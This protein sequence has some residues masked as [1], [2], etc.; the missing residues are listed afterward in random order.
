MH[1]LPERK[2]RRASLLCRFV[3]PPYRYRAGICRVRKGHCALTAIQFQRRDHRRC[4]IRAIGKGACSQ[5][6]SQ[7]FRDMGERLR[8]GRL[9]PIQNYMTERLPYGDEICFDIRPRGKQRVSPGAICP[10]SI[11]TRCARPVVSGVHCQLPNPSDGVFSCLRLFSPD[12]SKHKQIE[13]QKRASLTERGRLGNSQQKPTNAAIAR[14]CLCET[15]CAVLRGSHG[16]DA[17]FD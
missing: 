14:A 17:R 8:L 3:S 6:Y 12:R 4:S 11:S 1:R 15:R 16:R 10:Q 2:A 5:S 7:S 9:I 13:C